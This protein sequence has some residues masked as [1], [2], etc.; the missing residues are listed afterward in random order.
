MD[1]HRIYTHHSKLLFIF[2]PFS[3]SVHPYTH[4]HSRKQTPS[5][6]YLLPCYPG[7]PPTPPPL[8]YRPLHWDNLHTNEVKSDAVDNFIPIGGAEGGAVAAGSALRAARNN[9]KM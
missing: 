3:F 4:Y 1:I 8:D 6:L 7:V 5:F 9:K 2:L